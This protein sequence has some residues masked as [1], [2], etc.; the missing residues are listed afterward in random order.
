MFRFLHCRQMDT[1]SVSAGQAAGDAQGLRGGG[2]SALPHALGEAPESYSAPLR[3]SHETA[4]S[5]VIRREINRGHRK[6]TPY[7]RPQPKG[8]GKAPGLF[9]RIKNMWNYLSGKYTAPSEEADGT[10]DDEM[11]PA[12]TSP[13][14]T[15]PAQHPATF[16]HLPPVPVTMMSPLGARARSVYDEKVEVEPEAPLESLNQSL[17]PTFASPVPDRDPSFWTRPPGTFLVGMCR[18]HFFS[19]SSFNVS[20]YHLCFF[21]AR[22]SCGS[23]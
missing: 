20:L 19:L 18:T 14:P 1:P 6:N 16:R 9:G 5:S 15:V 21:V 3:E 12:R 7:A 4:G 2:A 13:Q 22:S 8:N 11:P 17:Y 10:D 23:D